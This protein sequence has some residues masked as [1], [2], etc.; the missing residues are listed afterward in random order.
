MRAGVRTTVA[1]GMALLVLVACTASKPKAP[2]E[3]WDAQGHDYPTLGEPTPGQVQPSSGELLGTAGPRVGPLT[4]VA[5]AGVVVA[6]L[7]YLWL[8]TRPD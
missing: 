3:W 8:E 2:P 5:A 4:L 7:A 1:L 6:G